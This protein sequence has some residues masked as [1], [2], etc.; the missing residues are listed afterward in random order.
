MASDYNAT[1]GVYSLTPDNQYVF[2]TLNWEDIQKYTSVVITV[3]CE[4]PGYVALNWTNAAEDSSD[5]DNIPGVADLSNPLAV[6]SFYYNPLYGVQTREYGVRAR[7]LNLDFSASTLADS[8]LVISTVYKTAPTEI[9]IGDQCNNW[10]SV[11]LGDKFHNSLYT[12]L[13]DLS[14][15]PV[16]ST[17]TVPAIGSSGTALFTTLA[18]SSGNSLATT[19]DYRWITRQL[20]TSLYP[21]TYGAVEYLTAD[22]SAGIIVPGNDTFVFPTWLMGFR[23]GDTVQYAMIRSN[24]ASNFTLANVFNPVTTSGYLKTTATVHIT[25]SPRTPIANAWTAFQLLVDQ[26]LANWFNPAIGFPALYPTQI[27]SPSV[28][29]LVTPPTG[30]PSY[31]VTNCGSNLAK[32]DDYYN[33]I[34]DPS[35][36]NASG[37]YVL[38]PGIYPL[39]MRL[40]LNSVSNNPT[41]I[42][43]TASAA[44]NQALAVALRDNNNLN[45][46]STG[47]GTTGYY[48]RPS[49][50]PLSG[51]GIILL[52]DRADGYPY[53]NTGTDATQYQTVGTDLFGTIVTNVQA[54]TDTSWNLTAS[55]GEIAMYAYDTAT[56]PVFTYTTP[57]PTTSTINTA[58]PLPLNATNLRDPWQAMASTYAANNGH[59]SS[60]VIFLSNQNNISGSI[61][62]VDISYATLGSVPRIVITPAINQEVLA[63]ANGGQIFTYD[64]SVNTPLI[65]SELTAIGT[66]IAADLVGTTFIGHNAL[67]VVP[68]DT[69][70]HAQAATRLVNQ[71][72]WAGSALYY[73]LADSCGYSI[74]ST[75][76]ASGSVYVSGGI[77]YSDYSHNALYTN[78]NTVNPINGEEQSVD[79][80]NRLYVTFGGQTF[81]AGSFNLAISGALVSSTDISNAYFNL[82]SLGIVNESPTTVWVKFYDVC[83][84]QAYGVTD[85]TVTLSGNL[86]YNLAVPAENTRDLNFSQSVYIHNGL[87]M[88]ATTTY[89]VDSSYYPYNARAV[90]VYGTYTPI[91]ASIEPT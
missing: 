88:L 2:N 29:Y 32:I 45:L 79:Y 33:L 14:G 6:N 28:Q 59:V 35:G 37:G 67:A 34:Q 69:S 51:Q 48:Y 1:Q 57:A 46:S 64:W 90:Y 84:G 86:I 21:I 75:F 39:E 66:E 12:L 24:A 58:L 65:P 83:V 11:N 76:S 47:Y 17:A 38:N 77:V 27:S 70:G 80:N 49:D 54:I 68:A 9:Q 87:Y 85:P 18:D 7:W 19:N 16:S 78:L 23:D 53:G 15:N 5:L 10:V 41:Y 71:A 73:A 22:M 30:G 36:L 81:N 25:D 72:M 60:F 40:Y 8:S 89:L 20:T 50:K 82:N 26:N 42:N 63:L 62:A 74:D 4:V 31:L 13:T 52:I 44:P 91:T 3:S 56:Y 55:L 61:M 43:L